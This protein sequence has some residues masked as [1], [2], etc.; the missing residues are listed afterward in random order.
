MPVFQQM[1]M[2]RMPPPLTGTATTA[3]DATAGTGYSNSTVVP[4]MFTGGS[5]TKTYSVSSGSLP[6]GLSLSSA[7]TIS[8]APGSAAVEYQRTLTIQCTDTSGSATAV[9]TISVNGV[10]TVD[11]LSG[12]GAMTNSTGWNLYWGTFNNGVMNIN[13]AGQGVSV[14]D[15]AAWNANTAKS[16]SKW[17]ITY[18]VVSV[19]NAGDGIRPIIAGSGGAYRTAPGTY[20]EDIIAGGA[21]SYLAFQTNNQGFTGSIDN[22][23][24]VAVV[25]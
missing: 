21:G 9:L 8:G 16:G 14:C 6:P 15:T 19:F 3:P 7:G 12:A 20:T 10:S 5:G 13:V 25:P 23:T 2:G 24:V 17:R 11:A 1:M 22:V 18:D 4:S